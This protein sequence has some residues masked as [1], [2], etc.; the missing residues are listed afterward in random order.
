VQNWNLPTKENETESWPYV[1][2]AP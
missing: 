2:V 1:H